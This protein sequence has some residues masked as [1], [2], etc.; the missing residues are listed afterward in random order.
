[1]F[2]LKSNVVAALQ[3][4]SFF[5]ICREIW[6]FEFS[7]LRFSFFNFH[8]FNLLHIPWEVIAI[9]I[10]MQINKSSSWQLL[11]FFIDIVPIKKEVKIYKSI[12]PL[13]GS[14]R[15][16]LLYDDSLRYISKFFNKLLIE[17]SIIF[18]NKLLHC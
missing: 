4:F 9:D 2:S 18:F 7:S 14:I 13:V 5:Q 6:I 3:A 10:K 16:I 15:A 1:M 8:F 12:Q 17:I 11:E